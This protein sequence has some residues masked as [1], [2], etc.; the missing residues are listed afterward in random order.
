MVKKTQSIEGKNPIF[1]KAISH[2][3]WFLPYT[4]P[5]QYYHLIFFF[6]LTL[7][8]FSAYNMVLEYFLFKIRLSCLD[9]HVLQ[10]VTQQ[11][12]TYH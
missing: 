7:K 12:E 3:D 2:P 5:V 4:Y 11:R 6:Q 10:N 1:L 9:C 8:D